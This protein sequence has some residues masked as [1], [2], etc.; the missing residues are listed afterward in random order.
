MARPCVIA[1]DGRSGAGKSTL[2]ARIAEA[3]GA[4]VIDSDDFFSGG[5]I[6]RSDSP[7]DRAQDCIDWKRQRPVLDALR[8][9]REASYFAFDWDAF[10]GRLHTAPT[11]VQ[12]RPVVL[13]AGVYTSRPEL[14]DLVD[15]RV[16]LHVSEAT[17]VARLLGRDGDIDLWQRQWHE[18]EEWYFRQVAP[19]RRFDAIL[20]E[21]PEAD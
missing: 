8:A 6:V 10:D 3:L 2:A 14:S 5:V 12:P 9:G 15:L 20:S 11:T 1:L 13:F 16:L 17:R 18:A 19:P 4:S 21:R 7:Q